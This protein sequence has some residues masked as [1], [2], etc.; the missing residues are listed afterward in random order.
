MSLPATAFYEREGRLLSFNR[1]RCP[2]GMALLEALDEAIEGLR[3]KDPQRLHL[4]AR[5]WEITRRVDAGVEITELQD[6][7]VR[8]EMRR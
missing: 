2:R 4:E 7:L 1:S 3:E 8:R 6:E 5:S